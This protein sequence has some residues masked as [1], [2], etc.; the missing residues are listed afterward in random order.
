MLRYLRIAVSLLSL[1]ACMLLVASWVRSYLWMDQ[2]IHPV[3][4]VRY[5]GLTSIEGQVVFGASDDPDLSAAFSRYGSIW[6]RKAFPLRDWDKAV[7]GPV[8]FFPAARP[9]GIIRW[10]RLAKNAYVMSKPGSNHYEVIVPYWLLVL[11]TAA[12]AAA[13]WIKWR[14][15][16]R[17]LI[18]VMTLVAVV[19]GL[20]FAFG[21]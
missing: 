6:I 12:L 10:P 15:S 11:S 14:F 21:R 7:G 8:P 19:L 4:A 1:I 3:S 17:T 13:P 5:F 20:T 18:I 16:L 2:Y 9:R